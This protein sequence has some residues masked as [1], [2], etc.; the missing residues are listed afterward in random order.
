MPPASHDFR[1]PAV[2]LV[3]LQNA[4]FRKPPLAGMKPGIVGN[5]NR[6]LQAARARHAPI[7]N[8][9][10]EHKADRSTWTLKMLED[11][12]GYLFEG[13]REAANLP[14]LHL[15]G[16]IEIIKRRDSAFWNTE[17]ATQLLQHRVTSLVIAGVSSQTCVAATASDAFSANLC[18]AVAKDAIA[19]D[20]PDF[21]DRTLKFLHEQHRQLVAD[22]AY[23]VDLI[24]TANHPPS[25]RKDTP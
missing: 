14:E 16:G 17:L 22:T 3:D 18:V 23:L 11:G 4:F 12:Q 7:F 5:C 20:D 25:Q 24:A 21:E 19:S 15:E 6:L 9:R 13:T 10:T 8:V 1:Y 2:V